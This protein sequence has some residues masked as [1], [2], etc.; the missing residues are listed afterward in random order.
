LFAL[1]GAGQAEPSTG[2]CEQLCLAT[3]N[4]QSFVYDGTTCKLFSV[5]AFSLELNAVYF[6]VDPGVAGS[7][8]LYDV[9]CFVC[10]PPGCVCPPPKTRRDLARREAGLS[11]READLQLLEA[12]LSS[13]MLELEP[14]AGPLLEK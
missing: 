14:D 9:G 4:C 1:N 13:R 11:R 6:P 8:P 5:S 7:V 10:L 3:S 2:N 12:E